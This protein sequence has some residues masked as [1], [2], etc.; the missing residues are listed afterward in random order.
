MENAETKEVQKRYP[1]E[2]CNCGCEFYAAKSILQLWGYYDNGCGSCPECGQFLNLTYVPK[3]EKMVSKK[4][5][6]YITDIKQRKR[7]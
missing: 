1:V 2:C 6:D 7:R 4:W 3:K 5:D